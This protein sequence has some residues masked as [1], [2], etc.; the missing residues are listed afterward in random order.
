[1]RG[2]RVGAALGLVG[3]LL[4]AAVAGTGVMVV[5]V[6]K[7][8]GTRL[9]VPIPLLLAQ[10]AARLGP[11]RSAAAEIDRQV[12]R[13]R[14]YLP[15]AEEVLAAVAESMDGELASVDQGDEHVRVS[16]VGDSLRI[17]ID[18][19]RERTELNVPFDLARRALQHARQGPVSPAAVLAMLRYSRLTQLAD[20]DNVGGDHVRLKIW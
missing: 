4:G 14:Q 11:A 8:D 15:V 3:V 16:K 7:A 19:P 1:M 18:N 20:V 13:V 10:A 5:D 12:A 17:H 2:R 6:K 9:V